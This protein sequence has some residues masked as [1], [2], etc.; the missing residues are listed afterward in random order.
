MIFTRKAWRADISARKRDGSEFVAG[1]WPGVH[2]PDMLNADARENGPAEN[3]R[4]F[5]IRD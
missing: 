4:C 2:S 1:V 3:I 5:L